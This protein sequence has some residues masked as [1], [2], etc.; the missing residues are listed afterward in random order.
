MDGL[1]LQKTRL[2]ALDLIKD[3]L[4]VDKNVFEKAAASCVKAYSIYQL[5]IYLYDL[6]IINE[7]S[8]KPELALDL[9]KNFLEEHYN[10]N[11]DTIA[12]VLLKNRNVDEAVSF[13]KSRL[14]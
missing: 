5:P 4:E 7:Y 9:F 3:G 2:S 14:S 13:A 12:N 11:Y 1:R 6:A 10:Y 8:G